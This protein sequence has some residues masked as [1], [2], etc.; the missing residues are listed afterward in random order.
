MPTSKALLERAG[1][2]RTSI[3]IDRWE[4]LCHETALFS[5]LDQRLV[6]MSDAQHLGVFEGK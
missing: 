5:V 1:L 4:C 6:K 3:Y 2:V